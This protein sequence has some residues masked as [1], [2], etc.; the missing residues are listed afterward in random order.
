MIKYKIIIIL[1]FF[2]IYCITLYADDGSW[3]KSFTIDAGSIYSDIDN[4]D[5]ELEKEILIF[6]GDF[7][8]A[9]FQFRNISDKSLTVSCGFPVRYEIE[10]FFGGDSLEI[11]ISSYAPVQN[12]AVLDYLETLPIEYTD[13]DDYMYGMK[14]DIIL[15]NEFNNSREFIS[16]SQ[17]PEDLKFHITQDGKTVQ[18]EKVL[19]DRY[20]G[21]EG[22]SVT[23]HYKHNLYFKPG[24]ISTVVVEYHQDLFNGSDGMSDTFLWKYIIGTGGTWNKAIGELI[25]IKPSEW[26]G[27]IEGLDL[28]MD[29]GNITIFGKTN[30]KPAR[31]E[32]YTLEAHFSNIMVQYEYLENK[33]PFLK[34]MW[35]NR[36]EPE[37]QPNKA[38]QTFI[39][40]ITASSYLHDSLPVFTNT[41]VILQAGFSP[42]ASF[43]GL[44][45]TSW[46]ENVPGDGI[47]EYIEITLTKDV[48]GLS[49]NNGFTRLPAEDW[50]FDEKNGSSI[51]NEKVRDD[52][53]GIKDY[54]SQNNRVKKLSISNTAGQIFYTLKLDDQRD[55]QTF[56]GIKLH[57]GT[58]R[59]IIEEVY[60]GTKWKDTCLGE[61]IFLESENIQQIHSI[62]KDQFYMEALQGV[63]FK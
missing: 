28:L 4:Q 24:D 22:A 57:S 48:W 36:S 23:F 35:N 32:V 20:A 42:T 63:Q 12:I 27:E 7:T 62:T 6:N 1:S 49:I 61:V 53:Q 3:N 41:G 60:P 44:K 19:L 45:E 34:K 46:C 55:L 9:V 16:P 52:L 47:G 5:I 8:K 51:F 43:D 50:L 15:N 17:T 56:P 26:K 54:Y 14:T 31:D 13:P 11:P 18:I 25:L 30:Y 40:N 59:L 10:A 37:T 2:F 33:L 38:V 29:D 21:E 58:Y 39:S